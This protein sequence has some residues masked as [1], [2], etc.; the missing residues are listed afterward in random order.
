MSRSLLLLA[1]SDALTPA[2]H[3]THRRYPFEVPAGCAGLNIEVRYQ[4]Q[5]LSAEASRPL[6]EQAVHSQSAALAPY[7]ADPEL[8]EA[9]R[10]SYVALAMDGRVANLVTMSLDDAAGAYRG[11][12][13]RMAPDQHW[14]LDAARAS[15]GMVAGQL[16]AGTWILTM[17][18]HTLVSAV[19]ELAIQIGA[20][21][22]TSRPPSARR[23]A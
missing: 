19:C 8:A 5:Y 18:V 15:D 17:T 14:Q 1:I 16:P 2:D 9:W 6:L 23:S 22:P 12:G 7:L 10:R 21:T 3:Q 4:P 20:D 13:H 11:A